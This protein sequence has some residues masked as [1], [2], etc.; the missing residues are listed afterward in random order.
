MIMGF[1]KKEVCEHCHKNINLG[2]SISECQNHH[3]NSIIHTRCFK[4]STFGLINN[5]IYCQNCCSNIDVIYNPFENLK[6][7][8]PSNDCIDDMH[9][10]KFYEG[11]PLEIID[12]FTTISNLLNN[13]KSLKT[14]PDLNRCITSDGITS[15]NFSTLFLNIDGNKSN[16]D[17]FAVDIRRISHTLSVIGIAE[18][19]VDPSNKDLYMLDDYISFYQDCQNEKSK[20]TGVALYV[21]N[22][23]NAT[24]NKKLSHTSQ[25]LE[26]LFVT[27]PV[28]SRSLTVGVLYRPPNGNFGEFLGELRHILDGSPSK[29]LFI[30]GDF[31][32]DLHKYT[33]WTMR[34]PKHTKNLS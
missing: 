32:I 27:I 25:N 10:D 9:S 18:T 16:F 6:A 2:Q 8:K 12:E 14:V 24:I 7:A 17:S 31:N 29:Y 11:D 1:L 22:S 28:E 34:M 4:K 26:T 15:S 3:C 33:K 23:L 30:M 13:C 20:G 19:N 5:K 21:H